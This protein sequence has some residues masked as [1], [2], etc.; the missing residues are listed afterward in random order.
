M[1]L[2]LLRCP[3]PGAPTGLLAGQGVP[4]V[5]DV[6]D[7]LDAAERKRAATL[8][9]PADRALYV[10]S[11]LALRTLLGAYLCV[12]AREVVLV[13]EP[14][15]GCGGPHG[16]PAV[17]GTPPPLHFSLSH[18]HGLALIGVASVPVGVDVQ[19]VPGPGTVDAC[20]PLLHPAERAELDRLPPGARPGAFAQLWARKEAYL[21]GIGTGL[22]RP[23]SADYL[24]A[25][26]RSRPH[27]WTVTDLP[28]ADAH[29]AAVAVLGTAPPA[30]RRLPVRLTSPHRLTSM[31]QAANDHEPT[32][33]LAGQPEGT[34]EE[35]A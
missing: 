19:R 3:E 17:P 22:S 35:T 34:H 16:R 1:D 9:R 29:T 21:K 28:R 30:V 20:A 31:H 18:S 13:R 10:A 5:L 25:D 8:R 32:D 14:C 24:G 7:V 6:R 15:P 11:H 2:W 27:G 26:T 4:D 33:Q 23:A 12:P